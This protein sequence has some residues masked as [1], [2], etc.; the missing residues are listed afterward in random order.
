VSE[1]KPK[2]KHDPKWQDRTVTERSRNRRKELNEIAVAIGYETWNK[3][4]TAIKAGDVLLI[5]MEDSE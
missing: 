5:K 2:R 1:E 3:L 4:V